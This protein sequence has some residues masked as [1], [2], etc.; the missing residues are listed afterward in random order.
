MNLKFMTF[1]MEVGLAVEGNMILCEICH[2]EE[3]TGTR[4]L[5]PDESKIFVGGV[6]RIGP[7]CGGPKTKKKDGIAPH[8]E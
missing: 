5:N 1:H 7:K 8:T 2:K 4:W 3:A 6:Y